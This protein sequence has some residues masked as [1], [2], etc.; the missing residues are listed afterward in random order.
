MEFSMLMTIVDDAI[1]RKNLG[2]IF[3]SEIF[4]FQY[5]RREQRVRARRHNKK[6]I[7]KKPL[8]SLVKCK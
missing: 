1:A 7:E 2:V 5:I 8:P 3:F 6:C 4:L